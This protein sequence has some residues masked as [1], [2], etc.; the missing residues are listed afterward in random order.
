MIELTGITWDHPRGYAPLVAVSREAEVTLRV[1][2]TWDKRSLKD[3]GDAELPAL[4]RDYDLVVMDH[5]HVGEAAR[6]GC[7]L[8]VDG[9]ADGELLAAIQRESAGSSYSSYH[10]N[11]RQWALPLDAA[12]QICGYR[13]DVLNASLLPDSW[14]AVFDLSKRL[15]K[16]GLWMGM[17]LCPTDS[18]CSFLTLA[19]QSGD[20]PVEA[21]RWI[22]RETTLS[23]LEQ[24]RQLRD[25]CHP[26][27][28]KWNPIALY[29]RM[30]EDGQIA[31]SPLAFGY[32]NYTESAF[33]KHSLAF[34]NPPGGSGALLGG[35]GLA[36]SRRTSNPEAA[37]AYCLFA[38]GST[39]QG[40]TFLKNGGQPG[41]GAAWHSAE[42]S[43]AIRQF[44]KPTLAAIEGAYVRPRSPGW[45]AFQEALGDHV[46]EWLTSGGDPVGLHENLES[47]YN[48]QVL[49]V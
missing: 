15:H 1:R 6:S 46:H 23:V 35:A 12:C 40:T 44:L 2:V 13:P 37:A 22:Q 9:V 7:L 16:D 33:R 17:A 25:A 34:G 28:L 32:I 26:D 39:C 11:G 36:I 21:K 48:E 41:N 30:A 4:A 18:L 19:A 31:Y 14:E 38:C 5:P 49:N 3:F 45:P 10:Y 8:P 47:L 27:S 29:D 20:P 24:L 42:D 43:P